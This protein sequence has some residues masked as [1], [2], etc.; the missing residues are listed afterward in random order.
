MNRSLML[1]LAATSML[2]LSACSKGA[3]KP[4]P[5]QMSGTDLTSEL[6]R[7][8]ELGLKAYDDPSCKQAQR[9]SNDRFL[10][11]SKGPGS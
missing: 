7:C 2:G 3:G 4:P 10:G 1:I 6:R 11:K 8:K 9:E 5:Q